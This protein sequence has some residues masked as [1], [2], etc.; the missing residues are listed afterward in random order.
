MDFFALPDEQVQGK[1]VYSLVGVAG[2]NLEEACA[3]ARRWPEKG[4]AAIPYPDSIADM[5]ATF[6]RQK[7]ERSR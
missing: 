3:T 6:S 4:E 5:T 2:D 1:I 7:T